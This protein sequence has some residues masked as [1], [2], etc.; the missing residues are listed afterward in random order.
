MEH[1]IQELSLNDLVLDT[2]YYGERPEPADVKDLA[3]KI[4]EIKGISINEVARVTT[5]NL[6]SLLKI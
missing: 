4:A 3:Q 6:K 1:V 5:S 2:D